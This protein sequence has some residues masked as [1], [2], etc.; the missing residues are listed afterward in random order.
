LQWCRLL[1]RGDTL[2]LGTWSVLRLQWL[3]LRYLRRRLGW[4][5]GD[6]GAGEVDGS[7]RGRGP[8]EGARRGRDWVLS[9]F[10]SHVPSVGLMICVFVQATASYLEEE[11]GCRSDV[12]PA[13]E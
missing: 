4:L 11:L 6:F 9:G 12:A 8:L 5:S 7:R 13:E 2:L 10:Y 1:A 3:R